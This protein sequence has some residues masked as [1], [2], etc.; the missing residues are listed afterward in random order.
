M[1]DV[2]DAVAAHHPGL[3]EK[4]GGHAM[5][6]GMTLRAERLP[7]FAQAF[8]AEVE[9]CAGEDTL[10]GDLYT[11]GPLAAGEFIADTAARPYG[12]C[13][14]LAIAIFLIPG[15]RNA[16]GPCWTSM[17]DPAGTQKTIR[18]TAYR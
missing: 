18:P 1:R 5:A 14:G 4:F 10:S 7:D 9:S 11:D 15:S 13:L 2:L 6:A 8:A 16:S 12:A 3:L 17:R